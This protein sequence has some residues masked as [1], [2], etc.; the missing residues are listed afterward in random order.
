MY[1]VGRR[2][3]LCLLTLALALTFRNVLDLIIVSTS[4]L[5]LAFSTSPSLKAL[6]L[7]RPFRVLRV[8]SRLASLR[9]LV[10][11]IIASILPVMQAFMIVMVVIA[12]YAV[13]GVNF[14]GQLDPTHFG[15]FRRALF[16][17]F[18][19]RVLSPF[20]CIR[21]KIVR[22]PTHARRG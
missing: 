8:F 10:N 9:M 3:G 19:A 20:S 11:A 21:Y 16:T 13:L 17:M 15:S 7:L 14:F 22:A 5:A 12:I 4:I 6:R 1:E 18:Q 2:P